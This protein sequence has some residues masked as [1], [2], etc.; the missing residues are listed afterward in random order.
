MVWR[1]FA[2]APKD[3]SYILARIGSLT[4]EGYKHLSGRAFVIRHEGASPSGFDLGW[5][6]HPGF[7]GLADTWFSHWCPLPADPLPVYG[8]KP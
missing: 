6:L 2:S 1:T 4:S 8:A 7:G 5:A 3:G